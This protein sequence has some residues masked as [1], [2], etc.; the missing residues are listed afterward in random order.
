MKVKCGIALCMMLAM[1]VGRINQKEFDKIRSL[2]KS[3]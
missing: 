1:A 3:A 2:I